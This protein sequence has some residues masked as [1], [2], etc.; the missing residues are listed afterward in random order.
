MINFKT[1]ELKD[2]AWMEPLI[3]AADMSG[4]HQN[5]TNIFAWA[6]TY[7]HRVA[8]V[9]DFLVVKGAGDSGQYYLYPAGTGDIKAVMEAI[10]QEA[11]NCGH[12]FQLAGVS[13][14]NIAE[15]NRL[16]PG[17]FDYEEMR[18]SYDYV[19]EL[20]K[21]VTLAGRKYQ[22]KRNHLNRFKQNNENWSFELISPENIDE[23]WKMNKEWCILHA[24]N[25]DDQLAK[26]KCA[27]TRCF[28]HYEALGLEGG[29][30]RSNNRVI[31]FTM[32]E[33][34]N[35]NTYVTHIEKAFGE[36]QGAYQMINTNLQ[37]LFK[38]SIL[39]SSM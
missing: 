21:L 39:K 17:N 6:E 1:V 28:D 31:A 13:P 25:E 2:K 15:I 32:G 29:L 34:L 27:V 5:F 35:S 10:R 7:Q 20:E 16:Y 24:C 37:L 19:Y 14:D 30:L 12:H 38:K 3:Q 23:C 18:D 11:G 26:E 4:C 22:A 33:K 36:I 8:R 9:N